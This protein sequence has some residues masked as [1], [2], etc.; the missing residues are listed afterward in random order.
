M[1]K[2]LWLLRPGVARIGGYGG[3]GSNEAGGYKSAVDLAEFGRAPDP[4]LRSGIAGPKLSGAA[5]DILTTNPARRAARS[6]Q[7]DESNRDVMPCAQG[8]PLNEAKL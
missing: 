8:V 6:G 7:F 1:L 4:S 3:S 2:N 5:L